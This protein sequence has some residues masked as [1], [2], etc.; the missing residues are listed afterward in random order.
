MDSAWSNFT[1]TVLPYSIHMPALLHTAILG[2]PPPRVG[3]V[4]EVYDLGDQVLIVATDRIS[5]F[6]VVMANGIPDKGAILNRMSAFWFGH[7]AGV[8]PSHFVSIANTD[9]DARLGGNHSEL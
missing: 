5:A 6:D 9:I 7:L 3:K 8:C 1:R 2:L 4:R